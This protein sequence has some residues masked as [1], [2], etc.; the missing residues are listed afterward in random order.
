MLYDANIE[1]VSVC[2][3]RACGEGGVVVVDDDDGCEPAGSSDLHLRL[4][5]AVAAAH[6]VR[7]GDCVLRRMLDK[8]WG[9]YERGSSR[10]HC[11]R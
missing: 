4:E 6:C 2:A 7:G 5:G 10:Q 1:R 11:Q 3:L 9:C 8:E